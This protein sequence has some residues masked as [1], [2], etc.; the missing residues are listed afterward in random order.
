MR[1][2]PFTCDATPPLGQPLCG[3][4][5]TPATEIVD[6]QF[7]H[8]IVLQPDGAEPVVLMAVDWCWIRGEAHEKWR[9][10]LAQAVGTRPNRVTIHTI[11]AH[12]A[13]MADVEADRLLAREGTKLRTLSPGY[14]DDVVKRSCEA[15]RQAMK[16][17]R[18]V[19]HIGTGQAKI[20]KVACNRRVVG[21]S[22]RVEL[23]RGSSCKDAKAIAAPD[24]L[25][26]TYLRCVTFWDGDACVAALHYYACHPMSFYGKGGVTPDFAG[27]ARERRRSEMPGVAHIYF[28]GCGGNIG[29]G[30]YNDGSPE[31]RPVLMGRLHA[32]MVQ[33]FEA[34][35]RQPVASFAWSAEPVHLPMSEE[36]TREYFTHNLRNPK[37][38]LAE[39]IKGA[40]GVAWWDRYDA[41]RKIDL[42]CMRINDIYF[43]HLAGEVFI[44]YQLAAQQMIAAKHGVSTQPAEEASAASVASGLR[45]GR[46]EDSPV[47]FAPR[48]GRSA[49]A[50]FVAVAAYGDCGPA[51]VPTAAAYPQGGYEITM[52]WVGPKAEGVIREAMRRL[53]KA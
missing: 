28:N 31:N 34:T 33:A 23:W 16:T 44:E 41:G 9:E 18:P 6:H 40:M 30:K 50:P 36:F 49:A 32:G 4:W 26:D 11:H 19:T 35:R 29:A 51:Y 3:G 45:A 8:G 25:I 53:I 5:I 48:G 43:L 52:A 1:I 38:T 12:D 42:T 7:A 21:P 2:A 14:L 10:S 47:A 22:G 17:S 13:A 20:E 37:G 15:A 39:R 46:D 24:G 27:L